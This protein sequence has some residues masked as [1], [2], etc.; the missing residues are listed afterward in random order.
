MNDQATSRSPLNARFVPL[1]RIHIRQ[2]HEM[3]TVFR[4]HYEYT[5]IETFMSDLSKKDGAIVLSEQDTGRIVGFSTI[6][7]LDMGRHGSRGA[8]VFS[9]DTIIEP[10]Y[11][12]TRALH[13]AFVRYIVRQKLRKPLTPIFWL[14]ISKGY[15]TYLL[16]AN[17]FEKYYPHPE[18]RCPDMEPLVKSYC[19]ALFPGHYNPGTGVLDFG[20]RAQR[21]K[22]GVAGVSE[23]LVREVPKVRF[24]Q[25]R[26]PT[27]NRGTELP[28]IG[29]LS[30][31]MLIKSFTKWW[32]QSSGKSLGRVGGRLRLLG[33]R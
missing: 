19:D 29:L 30:Y 6:V 1:N 14:L 3:Y 24:F 26:N 21:L 15:K 32:L 9:G 22:N 31:S 33:A 17:N 2:I 4:A 16:M 25:E 23:E 10:E 5:D 28:C 27:W 20:E 12:G 8:G 13:L 11:W 7:T 18:N